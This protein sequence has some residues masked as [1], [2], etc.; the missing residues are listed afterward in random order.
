M[1]T[2]PD[3]PAN[4]DGGSLSV[5]FDSPVDSDDVLAIGTFGDIARVQ[6]YLLRCVLRH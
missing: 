4:F 5:D 3:N 6:R 1:V 2:D